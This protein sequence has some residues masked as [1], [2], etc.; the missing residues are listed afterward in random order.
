MSDN[1]EVKTISPSIL[2]RNR[3]KYDTMRTLDGMTE[4]Q[5]KSTMSLDVK[6]FNKQNATSFTLDD[7]VKMLESL[8]KPSNTGKRDA[9][10]STRDS[11]ITETQDVLSVINLA[12][13]VKREAI[14]LTP[15][16]KAK[17]F[18]T[19]G[20]FGDV[21]TNHLKTAFSPIGG[22]SM[23]WNPSCQVSE[24][25]DGL[26]VYIGGWDDGSKNPRYQY[27]PRKC[28]ISKRSGYRDDS[29]NVSIHDM[30]P[31]A[32]TPK[33]EAEAETEVKTEAEAETE[34]EA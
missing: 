17:A 22:M 5:V 10:K 1:T 28:P 30:T 32:E 6:L 33:A 14:T 34:A 4:K 9:D 24:A 15:K 16:Q 20:D 31:K 7:Y 21:L 12:V 3:K 23:L 25:G 13:A 26:S 27:A 2:G 8:N 19:L 29:F 18:D 11:L